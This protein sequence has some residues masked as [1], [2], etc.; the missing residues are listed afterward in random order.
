MNF[1][2]IIVLSVLFNQQI[3]KNNYV[4]EV[5][6]NNPVVSTKDIAIVLPNADRV[7]LP[8]LNNIIPVIYIYDYKE[9]TKRLY[10]EY[11][12]KDCMIYINQDEVVYTT[13]KKIT[14]Q[15]EKQESISFLETFSSIDKEIKRLE[16]I[17]SNVDYTKDF[18][19]LK[20]KIE[21]LTAMLRKS[22]NETD[23]LKKSIEKNQSKEEIKAMISEV[24]KELATIQQKLTPK[25]EKNVDIINPALPIIDK[26]LVPSGK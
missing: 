11:A 1:A 15:K 23:L 7:K 26:E 9:N 14:V 13:P 4:Y 21:E 8:V 18:V 2:V 25:I 19:D 24:K 17:N 16:R 22:L 20:F 5:H 6:I 10:L 3:N 12:D